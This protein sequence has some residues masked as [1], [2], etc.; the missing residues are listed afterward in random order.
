MKIVYAS[1]TGNVKR[2]I[3]KLNVESIHL[4]TKLMIDEA[5]ILITYTTGFGQVPEEV[6]QFLQF[7]HH[8]M[9]GVVASGNRNWGSNFGKSA[10]IISNQYGVPVL[11]KFELSG[12]TK[13]LKVFKERVLL[14]EAY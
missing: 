11:H 3:E 14:V 2:F 7:N 1:K 6:E 10:D 9:V 13:D 4:H 5:F 12:T 8:H